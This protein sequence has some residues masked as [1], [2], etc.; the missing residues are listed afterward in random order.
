[1]EMRLANLYGKKTW[2]RHPDSSVAPADLIL[3]PL[4]NPFSPCEQVWFCLESPAGWV[5]W[6]APDLGL[7]PRALLGVD[8]GFPLVLASSGLA[9][10]NPPFSLRA[11]VYLGPCF[12]GNIRIIK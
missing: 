11:R 8:V 10:F 12:H 2:T 7:F 1:M 4:G 6:P 5:W 3:L 9:P